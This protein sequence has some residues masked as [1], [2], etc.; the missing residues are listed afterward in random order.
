MFIYENPIWLQVNVACITVTIN[1]D[2]VSFFFF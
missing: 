2:P 1:S